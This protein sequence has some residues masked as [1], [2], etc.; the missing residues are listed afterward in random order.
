LQARRR[1]VELDAE[2][3]QGQPA[4]DLDGAAVTLDGARDGADTEAG[5][6]G[7]EA[8]AQGGADARRQP[9][10]EAALDGALDA[11]DVDG[12][13]RSRDKNPNQNPNGDD[14]QVGD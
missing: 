3:D 8:V 7:D 6:K 2:G 11:E 12:P 14:E 10:P 5:K 13:D 4:D 1:D 9:S